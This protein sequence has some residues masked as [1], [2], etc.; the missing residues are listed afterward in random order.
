MYENSAITI[1]QS[2]RSVIPPCPGMDE[3]KSL[4]LNPRLNPEAKKP[5][6][7]AM[8]DANS[9]SATAWNCMGAACIVIS[10][11]R[12]WTLSGSLL[13]TYCTR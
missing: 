12:R 3:P 1:W 7:G 8:A 10:C 5:P 11:I 13:S 4:M 2:M 6:N 9:A